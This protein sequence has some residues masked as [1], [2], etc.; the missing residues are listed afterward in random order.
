MEKLWKIATDEQYKTEEEYQKNRPE[1]VLEYYG[2]ALENDMEKMLEYEIVSDITSIDSFPI[3]LKSDF[4]IKI[5]KNKIANGYNIKVFETM[6]QSDKL[7]PCKLHSLLTENRYDCSNKE[8][9]T[10]KIEDELKNER[11]KEKISYLLRHFYN[12][13]ELE[14]LIKDSG[15]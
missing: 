4:Y 3:Y 9:L 7:Y 12:K 5:P 15:D 10:N 6:Y 11:F 2:E 13:E 8:D 1:K 14:K